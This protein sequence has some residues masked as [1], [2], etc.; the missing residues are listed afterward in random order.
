MAGQ[1]LPTTLYTCAYCGKN[2]ERICIR[3]ERHP[4]EERLLCFECAEAPNRDAAH[5]KK[6]LTACHA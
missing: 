2:Y 6:Q 5:P 1:P 4:E 3:G